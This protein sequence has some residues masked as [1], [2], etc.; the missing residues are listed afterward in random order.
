MPPGARERRPGSSAQAFEAH[1]VFVSDAH[2]HIVPSPEDRPA[3]LLLDVGGLKL[4]FVL[5]FVA[6]DVDVV[7]VQLEPFLICSEWLASLAHG[8][9]LS[10][11][12]ASFARRSGGPTAAYAA[13][14]SCAPKFSAAV[15]SGW[16]TC[17]AADSPSPTRTPSI[18]SRKSS[19]ANRHSTFASMSTQRAAC[20][21]VTTARAKSSSSPTSRYRSRKDSSFTGSSVPLTSPSCQASRS[22]RTAVNAGTGWS[23]STTHTRKLRKASRSAVSSLKST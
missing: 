10:G 2:E 21:S 5:E 16:S 17:R 6:A 20:S 12:C 7:R 3:I 23:R 8:T 4:A 15:I 13:P 19:P 11:R 1:D 18:Q 9:G 14:L 22:L